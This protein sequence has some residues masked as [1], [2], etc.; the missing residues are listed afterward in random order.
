M[1]YHAREKRDYEWNIP[2][3]RNQLARFVSRRMKANQR[4]LYLSPTTRRENK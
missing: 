3:K 2:E 4:F 1:I